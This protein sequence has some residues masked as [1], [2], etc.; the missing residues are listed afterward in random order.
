[1]KLVEVIRALTTSDATYQ[2]VF[3]FAQS[4]GKALGD[5]PG[6]RLVAGSLYLAGLALEL[7]GQLP[8]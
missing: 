6:P 5:L 3:K 8:D 1:M 4:L 7:A 2:T